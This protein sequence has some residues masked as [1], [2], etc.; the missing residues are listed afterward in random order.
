MVEIIGKNLKPLFDTYEGKCLYVGMLCEVWEVTEET[1]NVI[2][3]I[4][5]EEFNQKYPDTTWRLSR[6]GKLVNNE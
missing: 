1:Y 6:E 2:S 3:S 4:P 5:K